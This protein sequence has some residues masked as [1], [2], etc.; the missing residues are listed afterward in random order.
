[1]VKSMATIWETPFTYSSYPSVGLVMEPDG[2]DSALLVIAPSG[3][4]AY[5]KYLVRFTKVFAVS[6]GE[7]A[8]FVLDLGQD[9]GPEEV[10]ARIWDASPHAAAY[11]DTVFGCELEMKHYVVFGGDNIASVVCGEPPVI[12][13]IAEPCE[14]VIRYAV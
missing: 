6:C 12:E 2:E 4:D 1:M 13:T 7:E 10:V 14:L 8:G 9:Q 3:L 11:L 5:P